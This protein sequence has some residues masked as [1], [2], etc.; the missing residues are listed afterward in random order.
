MDYEDNDQSVASL[1][2][3]QR[4]FLIYCNRLLARANSEQ[5]E[6]DPKILT[7]I[8]RFMSSIKISDN[9]GP[10]LSPELTEAQNK[11]K[12]LLKAKKER[13]AKTQED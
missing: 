12:G 4:Q 8:F 7:E 13:Q 3:F 2:E 5:T 11:A 1:S 9:E 10:T 6:I